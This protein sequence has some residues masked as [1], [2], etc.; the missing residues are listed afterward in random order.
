ME[1][2]SEQEENRRYEEWT[3]EAQEDIDISQHYIQEI[4]AI[5]IQKLW[6]GWVAKKSI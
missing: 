3:R 1:I 5:K 4:S 2:V 6:R